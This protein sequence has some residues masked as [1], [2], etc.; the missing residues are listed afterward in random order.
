MAVVIN[1]AAGSLVGRPEA[2]REVAA[3]LD[4]A[5]Y[6]AQVEADD[7]RGLVER[8]A[9]AT[10][11]EGAEAVVVGGGDGTIACAAQALVGSPVALGILPLGTMNILAKD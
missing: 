1:A 6:E 5:G 11:R 2:P 7:G 10:R 3:A 4:A 9:A 8:I